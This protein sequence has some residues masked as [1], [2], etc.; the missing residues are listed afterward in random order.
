MI[1]YED[2]TDCND[3]KNSVL[4]CCDVVYMYIIEWTYHNNML[5][6]NNVTINMTRLTY[7]A[8]ECGLLQCT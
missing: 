5:Y 8:C 3:D 2:Y 7:Y 6:L 1:L 4:L